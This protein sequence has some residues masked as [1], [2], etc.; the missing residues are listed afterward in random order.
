MFVCAWRSIHKTKCLLAIIVVCRSGDIRLLGG[1]S[2]YK[3]RV[4]VCIDED[5]GTICGD[6]WDQEGAMVVCRQLGYLQYNY[7]GKHSTFTRIFTEH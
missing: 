5:W 6:S 7:T 4:E 2:P 3:G 1:T